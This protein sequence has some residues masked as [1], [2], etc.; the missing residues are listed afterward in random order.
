V[1]SHCARCRHDGDNFIRSFYLQ[2]EIFN[3]HEKIIEDWML[4]S[5][6]PSEESLY[7]PI[8]I[9]HAIILGVPC[10]GRTNVKK[11]SY[12]FLI[13]FLKCVSKYEG[14]LL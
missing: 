4:V 13:N 5:E 8:K 6:S 7:M 12:H 2:L 9:N 14:R 11:P 1:D 3:L 10:S